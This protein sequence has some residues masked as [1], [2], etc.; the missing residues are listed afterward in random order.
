VTTRAA[1]RPLM[2]SKRGRIVNVASVVGLMGNAGQVNYA[3]SKGGLIAFTKSV[4]RE[5]AGRSVTAN[6]V[7]P[8]YVSTDMTANLPAGASEALL[9]RIPLARLGTV[10]DIA[11]VVKFLASPAAGYVTG[12]VICVDGGMVM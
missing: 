1:A 12:Q 9:G 3:A 5:L 8:G 2:K 10:E 11:G 6:V 4:A 7:A